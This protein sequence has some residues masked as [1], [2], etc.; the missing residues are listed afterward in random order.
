M[1]SLLIPVLLAVA[2]LVAACSGGPGG[3]GGSNG[4][5]GAPA[6]TPVLI[7]SPEAA[8]RTVAAVTPLFSAFPA[9]TAT[10]IGARSWYEAARTEAAKP[11][12]DWNVT[13]SA[14]WGDCE[15]GCITVHAWTYR[16][17]FDGSVTF[18]SETGPLVPAEVIAPLSAAVKVTGAG[19]RVLAGPACGGPVRVGQS[20]CDDR[21]V[22][23]AVLF[24]KGADG[25]EVAR[26]TTDAS[27]LFRLALQPGAYTLEPQPVVGLMGTAAPLP[28]T[29]VVGA[30]TFLDV[31]Y[32]TGMR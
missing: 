31:A 21:P 18:I 12:T 5:S 3:A 9:K 15:A 30:E 11:P 28:F 23:S 10:M 4:P 16:V 20:G 32:D 24:V 6:P 17:G 13:F 25:T 2:G 29:V 19:G 1:R 22:A 8:A 26:A 27:G 7:D 14:G